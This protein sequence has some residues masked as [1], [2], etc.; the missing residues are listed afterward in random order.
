MSQQVPWMEGLALDPRTFC[1]SVSWQDPCWQQ[2]RF[3][4]LRPWVC[5]PAMLLCD[6]DLFCDEANK[7]CQRRNAWSASGRH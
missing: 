7:R 3:L 2:E 1:R 4:G 5:P 6:S